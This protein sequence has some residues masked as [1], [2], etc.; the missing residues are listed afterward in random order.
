MSFL[1]P[2]DGVFFGFESG[3]LLELKEFGKCFVYFNGYILILAVVEDG[4]LNF[5][6]NDVC[7]DD[8]GNYKERTYLDTSLDELNSLEWELG[9]TGCFGDGDFYPALMDALYA[10]LFTGSESAGD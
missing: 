4:C 1:Q 7:L 10:L 8:D 5:Y 3:N 6:Y 2:P 9:D